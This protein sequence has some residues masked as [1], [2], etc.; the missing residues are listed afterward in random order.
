MD[1]VGV[2]E[3]KTKF[4]ELLRR[5]ER[6]E[7]VTITRH[8][9]PVAKLTPCGGETRRSMAD[10][11]KDVKNLRAGTRTGPESLRDLI[12]AGRKY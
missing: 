5:V 10:I 12:N 4:P 6:G 8:G 1:G 3:A 11:V 2:Y 7:T 9:H